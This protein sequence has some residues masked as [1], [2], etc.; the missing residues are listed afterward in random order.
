L[1]NPT[2]LCKRVA[3]ANPKPKQAYLKLLGQNRSIH[4][5]QK[6]R[7]QE[8][9]Q[10]LPS[11]TEKLSKAKREEPVGGLFRWNLQAFA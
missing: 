4:F 11:K 3:K 5:K 9:I 1:D 8:V 6:N 10:I 2:K 7:N